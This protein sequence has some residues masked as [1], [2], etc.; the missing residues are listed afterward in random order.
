MEKI[1][2]VIPCYY[3]EKTV[4]NVVDE[5]IATFDDS[6]YTFEVILVNDGSTDK[7]KDIIFSISQSDS[8]V[9]AVDLSKNV[10]QDGAVLAGFS[11]CTGDY[12]VVLD[13]D[14]QNPPLEAYKMLDLLKNGYDVVWG[15]YHENKH[16]MPRRIASKI[17][18]LMAQILLSKPKGLYLCGY[19]ATKKYV[20]DE[21]MKYKG[22]YPY[23][24]GLLLRTTDK[25]TN[26]YIEHRE[27]EVGQSTYT[28]KKL[29]KLWINGFTSF[30]IK[31][32][33]VASL[34]GIIVAMLGFCGLIFIVIKTL[35]FGVDA[36]G[37]ASLSSIML[38]L[39][40]IQLITIGMVGEYVGRIFISLNNSPQYV[41]REVS[42]SGEIS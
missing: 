37:W 11:K 7:T 24:R 15:K 5:V 16:S 1:S 8:R 33:R 19:F 26:V 22:P 13:D 18:D 28:F 27:R 25:Y 29:L 42:R 4:K 23:M 36:A 10:G 6:D 39:G 30:S 21:I 17:N 12:I 35:A 41:I 32:L 40:G 20:V 34:I 3:S 9:L 2:F 31:P 14:G 38:F